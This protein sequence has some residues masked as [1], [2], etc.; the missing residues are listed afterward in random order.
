MVK[1]RVEMVKLEGRSDADKRPKGIWSSGRRGKNGHR[2]ERNGQGRSEVVKSRRAAAERPTRARRA[3]ERGPQSPIVTTLVT[4]TA[5]TTA[6]TLVTTAVT[7]VTTAVSNGR[8]RR[9]RGQATAAQR[10]M[11]LGQSYPGGWSNTGQIQSY[12][13]QILVKYSH[14]PGE[15]QE[16]YPPGL[17]ESGGI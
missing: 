12:T 17:G 2:S 16:S 13:G 14:I 6:T 4:T 8:P 9:H 10:G 5:T 7:F 11:G 15:S 1:D 3:A